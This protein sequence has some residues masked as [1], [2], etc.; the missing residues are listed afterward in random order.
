M[1]SSSLRVFLFGM[2]FALP[3]LLHA[4]PM[5]TVLLESNDNDVAGQEVYAITYNTYADFLSNNPAS[6]T[7]SFLDINAD[8]SLG[9]F[10]FEPSQ[11][12]SEDGG[13]TVPEPSTFMLL[14]IGLATCCANRRWAP[15]ARNSLSRP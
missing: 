10:A 4:A 12:G 14:A 15:A 13:N 1:F 2:I 5:Y 6:A 7:F 9:G 11:N 3:G 8:Y